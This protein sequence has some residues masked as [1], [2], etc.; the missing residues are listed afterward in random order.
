[1][2]PLFKFF[3]SKH[4]RRS[5]FFLVT[6]T[7]LGTQSVISEHS[8]MIPSFSIFSSSFFSLGSMVRGTALGGSCTRL[9]SSDSLSSASPS[10]RPT[11]PS[12]T[13]GKMFFRSERDP[14]YLF[15]V[16]NISSTS[17]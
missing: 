10:K 11:V 7:R 1:M 3:G 14:L 2:R 13:S 9:A 5:P 15:Q 16:V 4:N 8:Q 12:K 6:I 17:F